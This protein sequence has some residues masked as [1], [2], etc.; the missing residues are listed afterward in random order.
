MRLDSGQATRM[1]SRFVLVGAMNPCPCGQLGWTDRPCARTPAQVAQ[2]RSRVSGPLLDRFEIQVDVPPVPL[3]DFEKASPGEPAAVVAA[4][5]VAARRRR[6]QDTEPA[7]TDSALRL[8]HQAIRRLGLSARAH[9]AI[10]RVACTIADL[11]GAGTIFPAHVAEAVQYR[12]LDR[13]RGELEV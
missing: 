12:A 7:P 4:R 8:L 3:R 9:D 2:Y 11:E 5:V 1:P 6:E 13:G 10:F